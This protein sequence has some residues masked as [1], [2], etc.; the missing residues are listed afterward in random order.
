M[1]C[2]K[3][4]IADFQALREGRRGRTRAFFTDVKMLLDIVVPKRTEWFQNGARKAPL[5]LFWQR[6]GQHKRMRDL[7][8]E[9]FG[10]VYIV[11]GKG[12]SD[13]LI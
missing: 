2:A 8:A 9:S 1:L 12:S 11:L 6:I 4:A 13:D 3:E 5:R 7:A 10:Y